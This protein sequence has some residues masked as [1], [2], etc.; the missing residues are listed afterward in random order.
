MTAGA[1]AA[2]RRRPRDRK[3]QILR[4][5]GATFWSSGY[6]AIG[7]AQVAGAVGIAPSALYRHFGSKQELLLAV[8]DGQLARRLEAASG[9]GGVPHLVGRL[10]HVSLA[11]REFGALYEREAGHLPEADRQFLR[12][13]LR[14]L[15]EAV[16][17]ALDS[18]GGTDLHAWALLAVL[19]SPSHHHLAIDPDGRLLQDAAMAV[20]R[21]ELPPDRV[22]AVT[23]QAAAAAARPGL[24]PVTRREELLAAALALFAQRGYPSVSLSDIGTVAGIAGPSVYNHF[25]SK[26]DLLVA[27][28]QRGNEA[29]WLGLHRALATAAGPGDALNELVHRH[30]TFALEHTDVVSVLLSEAVHLPAVAREHFH[31]LQSDYVTE[32]T[33]LL[34]LARPGLERA[35]AR[36]LVHA[37]LTIVNILSRVPSLES[38][39]LHRDLVAL[40]RAALTTGPYGAAWG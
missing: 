30:A 16:T 24:A 31:R 11:D 9:D 22:R 12:Q 34:V 19:D 13:R 23:R 17:R 40:A 5:A 21:T 25:P 20:A 6:H 15:A 1:A 32:W 37:A 3:Q 28:L 27:A 14:A 33:E 18:A 39:S 36:V 7:M 38:P 2:G 4:V 29:L 35:D 26:T 10:A 8:L